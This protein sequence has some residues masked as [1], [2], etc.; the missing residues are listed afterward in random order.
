MPDNR[1][2][3]L[4]TQLATAAPT[5]RRAVEAGLAGEEPTREIANVLANAQ[6]PEVRTLALAADTLRSAQVGERVGYVVNR[7]INFTN[8]CVKA[9]KF[10]AFSRVHRSEEAYF[11][12][13]EAVTERARQAMSVGATEVC[14]QAGLPPNMPGR[15]YIDLCRALTEA[16][17]GLHVHGFSPEEVRYGAHRANITV[18]EYLEALKDAGLG[19]LP[20]TSAEILDDELREGLA[21]TRISTEQWCEVITTAHELGLPTTSTMMFGHTEEP[22][23]W[24]EHLLLLRRL[25]QQTGG[26]TEFVPL[27]FIHTEA[28]LFAKGLLP[29]VRPG[30]TRDESTTVFALSRLLLGDVIPNV[31]V[32]WVKHGEA[33]AAR[34]LSCGANDLG[35]TLINESISTTA[36]ASHGQLMTPARLRGLIESAGRTPFQRDTLYGE[37]TDG[38]HSLDS[39]AGED[40]EAR[41]GSYIALSRDKTVSYRPNWTRT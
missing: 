38:D 20:G 3:E 13:I 30:P 32:S 25:Q 24:V 39:L 9:C 4:N 41:F 2:A 36:G 34:L 6:G 21:A 27:A 16:L 37:I 10:C 29:G 15:Y 11:L 17:P 19:S 8:V 31:Q 33:E 14:V 18:R 26:F 28:P 40:A 35:G 7:N 12:D 22:S 23:H 1:A 5:F